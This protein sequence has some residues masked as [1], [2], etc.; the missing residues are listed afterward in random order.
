MIGNR[1]GRGASD[2]ARAGATEYPAVADLPAL[3][4]TVAEHRRRLAG[5]HSADFDVPVGP[6]EPA[7]A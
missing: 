6:G 3:R 1:L 2:G 4:E 7:P 5:H